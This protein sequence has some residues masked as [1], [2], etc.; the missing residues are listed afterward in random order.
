MSV[1]R[2]GCYR[3]VIELSGI[4]VKI[5]NPMNGWYFFIKGILANLNEAQTA[6]SRDRRLCPVIFHLL[7][8]IIIMP[9]CRVLNDEEFLAFDW[10]EFMHR[11]DVRLPC[12]NKS[13]SFGWF[14]DSVVCIDYDG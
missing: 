1:N 14:G 6:R 13:N 10:H 8:F 5:P 11:G 12:E 2:Q 4:V 9:R 3:L 7:G